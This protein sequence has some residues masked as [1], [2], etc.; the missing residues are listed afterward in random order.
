[1]GVG[2]EVSYA[3]D[4]LSVAHSLSLLPVDQNVELFTP[5]LVS[6]LPACYHVSHHD[7][8]GL[9]VRNYKPDGIKCCPS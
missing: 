6:C 5:S 4:M 7:D 3:Q 2:F 8:N 1:V 9:K